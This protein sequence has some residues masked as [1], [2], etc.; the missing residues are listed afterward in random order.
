MRRRRFV[1]QLVRKGGRLST[2]LPKRLKIGPISCLSRS[3]YWM[4]NDAQ[5][6][7]LGAQRIGMKWISY[8]DVS[9]NRKIPGRVLGK[10]DN[11]KVA[12]R[13]SEILGICGGKHKFFFKPTLHFRRLNLMPRQLKG[14]V[15]TLTNYDAQLVSRSLETW[16][17]DVTDRN[18][19]PEFQL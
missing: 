3:T 10:I 1:C 11:S 17:W 19:H 7:I 13:I 6:I 14:H 16:A 5:V 12:V 9:G 4:G 15:Q 8:H 18:C 2:A